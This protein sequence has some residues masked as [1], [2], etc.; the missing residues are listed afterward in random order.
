[1]LRDATPDD[2]PAILELN[3]TFVSV[4]S[5]LDRPGLARLH[6]Q[7]ALHRVIEHDGKIEAFLLVLREGLDYDSPNYRWF[8]AR[9]ARFLYVDR[10]VVAGNTQTRGAGSELYRD[11]RALALRDGV[12]II[13]CE[14]DIE[15]PNPASA[16]FHAKL[17]FREVGQQR[18]RDGRKVVS[19]QVLDVAAEM[20]VGAV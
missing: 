19:M 2:F 17:G 18:I 4:L 12:P 20:A 14:F 3:E 9:H 10:I 1:M 6:A 5:P 8:A 16:R 15:P 7:A 13:A 11:A